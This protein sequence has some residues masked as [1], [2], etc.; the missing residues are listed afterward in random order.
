MQIVKED[1]FESQIEQ[2][3]KNIPQLG[4]IKKEFTIG[5]RIV[6]IPEEAII[7]VTLNKFSSCVFEI[8][9]NDWLE[10]V[11]NRTL[12]YILDNG[13]KELESIM[14]AVELAAVV[15]MKKMGCKIDSN[16]KQVF[17]IGRQ[18]TL[19]NQGFFYDLREV[20][21]Q[22]DDMRNS[23]YEEIEKKY[24]TKKIS[25]WSG[26]GF[27]IAGAIKGQ[28]SAE[29]MNLGATAISGIANGIGSF[30]DKRQVNNF[31]DNIESEFRKSPEFSLYFKEIWQE[32]FKSFHKTLK[33]TIES[34]LNIKS[35]SIGYNWGDDLKFNFSK[36]DEQ[37]AIDKL[38]NDIYDINAYVNLY[39]LN[40]EYGKELCKMAD[41]CGFLDVV[42]ASFLQYD[43]QK[44]AALDINSLGYDLPY[45]RLKSIK[46]DIDGLE[47]NNSIFQRSPAGIF[48]KMALEY[49]KNFNDLSREALEGFKKD[50]DNLGENKGN[51]YELYRMLLVMREQEYSKKLNEICSSVGVKKDRFKKSRILKIKDKTVN[52]NT[53]QI[54][55][56][57][58]IC[59]KDQNVFSEIVS[60][61]DSISARKDKFEIAALRN[62]LYNTFKCITAKNEDAFKFFVD[63]FVDNASNLSSDILLECIIG[64]KCYTQGNLTNEN[65]GV[66][67][68]KLTFVE[69]AVKDGNVFAMTILGDFYLTTKTQKE[70]G[71]KLLEKASRGLETTALKKIGNWYECGQNNYPE[72]KEKAKQYFLISF[73]MGDKEAETLIAKLQ[74]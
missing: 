11:N 51:Y 59:S 65:G 60:F 12:S 54:C 8:S 9:C 1:I 57:E 64:R 3:S 36:C 31:V 16:T 55:R 10:R 33:R 30:I 19:V 13:K 34:K 48:A 20:K 7:T 28:I 26:G 56:L 32:H 38:N 5:D 69:Q 40:R 35:Q 72:D 14:D 67:K 68:N 41:C 6:R 23:S 25:R 71:V 24:T 46:E 45:E 49:S 21:Y 42:E 50:F 37:S 73:V 61:I 15:L 63:Y 39:L 44:I 22:L 17:V 52:Q 29:I 18:D 47:E 70:L 4:N 66:D 53:E 43:D 58:S 2:I 62:Q 74:E 27:G